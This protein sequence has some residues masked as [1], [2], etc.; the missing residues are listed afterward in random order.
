VITLGDTASSRPTLTRLLARLVFSG[1][2]AGG[3]VVDG[4]V[5]LQLAADRDAIGGGLLSEGHLFRFQGA[6]ALLAA[7]LV[8]VLPWRRAAYA[9]AFVVAASALGA[10]VLYR[11]VNVGALGPLPNMY[12]PIWYGKKT[13]SAIA[14]LIAVVVSAAAL[15][16]LFWWRRNA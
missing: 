8:L 10:V 9:T 14:E 11:Y 6:F 2:T 1:L 4:V 5:H 12:E 7:A 16:R 3:L 13:V 15:A